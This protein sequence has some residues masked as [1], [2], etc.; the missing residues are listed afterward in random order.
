MQGKP[1][2]PAHIPPMHPGGPSGIG[3]GGQNSPGAQ[4]DSLMALGWK[5]AAQLQPSLS[6]SAASQLTQPGRATLKGVGGT[7]DGT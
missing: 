7:V 6:C 3:G 1:S 4:G 2:N 5:H